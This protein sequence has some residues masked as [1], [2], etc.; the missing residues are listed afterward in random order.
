MFLETINDH[1]SLEQKTIRANHAPNMR[2]AMMHISQLEQNIEN[3][4]RI[5]T[6][7]VTENKI[8]FAAN[9]IKKN[10]RNIIQILI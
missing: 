4:Q 10:R 8:I 6:L 7:S 9:Y 3:N 2:K 1:A 5:S